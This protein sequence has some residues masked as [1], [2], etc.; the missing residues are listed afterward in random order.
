VSVAAVTDL[1]PS[2]RRLTLTGTDLHEC[3]D[4][5]L[6]QR[7]KLVLGE[8]DPTL[9]THEWYDVWRALPNDRRPT[10][11]TYSIAGLDRAR[12]TMD[13]DVACWPVH[14]PASRFAAQA[15]P[16]DGLIVVAPDA[17]SPEASSHGI[18]WRPGA[19]TDVLIV[20]DE[21][22]L[23]AIRNILRALPDRTTGTTILEL[24]HLADAVELTAPPGIE[25]H[26]VARDGRPVGVAAEQH[27]SR[28]LPAARRTRKPVAPEPDE[29]D[30]WDEI[31]R[32][33]RRR[34]YG[35]FAGEAG[36]IV[37]LRR[38]ARSAPSLADSNFMGY[39]KAGKAMEG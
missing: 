2:F 38:R 37:S 29:D 9:L 12:S 3:G 36:W 4:A 21:T 39:W 11:R 32:G 28:I 25:L 35:W 14:G 17:Q 23:P 34:T 6:D 19:A 8:P 27:L 5:M 30:L 10:V 16:G 7:I 15:V 20:G 13:V 1:S 31:D 26:L 18:A 33:H 24:P 22:A